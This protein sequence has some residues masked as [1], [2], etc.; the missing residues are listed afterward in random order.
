[1]CNL[2][3][4]IKRSHILATTLDDEIVMMDSEKGMYYNLDPI[5]SCIWALLDTPQTLESLCK[6]LMNDYD[7]DETTC[8]LET[9]VFLHSLAERGLITI[10]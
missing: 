8:Q 2:R 3:H 4:F 1:M 9:E 10:T 6:S 7:I 5:G